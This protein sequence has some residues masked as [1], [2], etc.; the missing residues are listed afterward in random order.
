MADVLSYFH[1]VKSQLDTESSSDAVIVEALKIFSSQVH[2]LALGQAARSQEL[3]RSLAR[4]LLALHLEGEGQRDRV[5]RIVD[6]FTLDALG[7]PHV[8]SAKEAVAILGA[9][10]VS[11]ASPEVEEA[12]WALYREYAEFFELDRTFNVK[13]WMWDVQE[14]EL[15]A[16]GAAAES[17]DRSY[18]FRSRLIV[19]L[20]PV[21]PQT[22]TTPTGQR[23]ESMPGQV[24]PPT[25]P[26]TVN[27][28]P[29]SS[30]WFPNS[31]D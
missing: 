28:E 23:I 18:L 19:R 3:L 31:V 7:P 10:W 30:G 26:T 27:V 2:P 1:F 8:I 11:V 29:I 14:K 24:L 12:L 9:D 4:K 13:D 22:Q 21:P 20:M 17:K 5:T 6:F 16:M 25:L 15:L